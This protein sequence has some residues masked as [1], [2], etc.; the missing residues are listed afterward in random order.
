[1]THPD[2][3]ILHPIDPIPLA[4]GVE[5][6]FQVIPPVAVQEEA[7]ARGKPL[8]FLM[9]SRGGRLEEEPRHRVVLSRPFYLGTVPVTQEQF[10]CWKVGH[11]NH[12]K[13]KPDHP[14]EKV[15]WREARDFCRWVQDRYSAC[16]PAGLQASLPT[17]AQWEY[18][19]RAGT[20]TEYWSGNGTAALRQVAWFGEGWKKGSTHPVGELLVSPW[21]LHDMHGNV[22]EWCRDAWEKECHGKRGSNC[23]DPITEGDDDSPRV[24]RGGSWGYRATSCHSAVRFGDRPGDRSWHQGFR[25]CLTSGPVENEGAGELF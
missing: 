15:T 7:L 22:W 8:S 16:L 25:L 9:G 14:A 24:I 23:S 12:F 3:D 11:E 19:C 6:T 17:E 5:M 20:D 13:G 2:F 18:A 4:E 21:G 10:A 1:M